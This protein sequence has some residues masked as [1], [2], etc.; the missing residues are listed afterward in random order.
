MAGEKL[1]ENR[2]KK[3]LTDEGC[4]FIKYW[5]GAAYTKTGIPDLL[6]CCNGYFVAAEV[7]SERGKPS[8]LQLWT[9]K[10]IQDAGGRALV[11]YPNGFEDF[12]TLIRGLKEKR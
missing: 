8:K 5:A 1:F 9:I 3:F 4:W 12:K 6:I 11:L 7:K 10:R 2:V